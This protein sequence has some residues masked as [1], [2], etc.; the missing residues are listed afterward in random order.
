MYDGVCPSASIVF[1]SSTPSRTVCCSYKHA[2]PYNLYERLNPLLYTTYITDA[3]FH[4]LIPFHSRKATPIATPIN[5]SQLSTV[6]EWMCMSG[7]GNKS[8]LTLN[9]TRYSK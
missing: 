6:N 2:D 7:R 5:Y 8:P 1:S 9:W 3:L 4:L